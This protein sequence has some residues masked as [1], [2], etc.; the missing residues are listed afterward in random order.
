MHCAPVALHSGRCAS[1]SSSAPPTKAST[2][3]PA[4]STSTRS[5]RSPRALITHGH[6]D[7]ARRRPRRGAGDA[8]R[9][10]TSWRCATARISPARRQAAALGEAIDLDGV[11]RHASTRP[12]TCS[13]RRRSRSST[14]GLAHRRLGRLQAPRRPDLRAVRAG[15]LRRL[16]HRGDLRP[17]GLPPSRRP[18]ARSRKLLHSVAQ[19]PERTH[20]VGAYALGKAQRVI[21]AAPRRRLRRA[22]LHPRRAAR[23]CDYYAARGHRPRRAR[24]GDRRERR[25]SA[26]SP[27]PIVVGPPSAFADRWARRF[28]DPVVVLRLRLDA[29]PPARQAARRRAAADHLRPLPTGTSSPTPSPRSAPREVWVTHGREEALVR[30]CELQGIPAQPLHLVGYEDEAE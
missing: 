10:S 17:A 11:A 5:G 4:I 9:R 6:S 20:L 16:H 26:I 7:H 18:R 30:W 19:F 1:P 8:A 22:D 12:A 28:P 14:D 15:R 2:A 25:A 21:R 13:A 3:R 27:A 24:A 29:H 23:L